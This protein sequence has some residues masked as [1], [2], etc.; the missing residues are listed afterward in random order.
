MCGMFG[1]I[2]MGEI[3][4]IAGIAL[5]VIGPEKFP[6]FAKIAL[7]AMHDLRT[8]VNDIQNEV[9]TELNPIKKEMRELSRFKAEDVIESLAQT[10]EDDLASIEASKNQ[11]VSQHEP[12]SETETTSSV[13]STPYPEDIGVILTAEEHD[14]AASVDAS[15]V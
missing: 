13:V 3:I 12:T 8:Y 7:R 6:Q 4:L 14:G 9:S 10:V 1:S 11:D 15:V 5:V 2:G